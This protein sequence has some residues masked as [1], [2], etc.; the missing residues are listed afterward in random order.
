M[1]EREERVALLA[2]ASGLAGGH[3]LGAL[4]EAPDFAR[5]YA[6]TRR[7]LGREHPRLA[8]RIV[9]FDRLEQQLKGV[10]CHTAFCCLGAAPEQ[11]PDEAREVELGYVLAFARA[12]K[13]ARAERFVF[14]SCVGAQADARKT[15]LRVKQEA[16]RALEGVG[17]VSLDILQPGPLVG[18]RREI[19]SADLLA[20]GHAAF[21]SLTS[22]GERAVQRGISARTVANAM[23][24]AARSGRRG[25]YRNTYSGIGMLARSKF[26]A[27][28]ARTPVLS[29]GPRPPSG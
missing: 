14:L 20:L 10:V 26:R 7:P 28:P 9:P 13:A 19:R 12:A 16:E 27:Q 18:I 22:F 21:L 15:H 17:F 6:V 5:V 24:G 2:G 23:L 8:N 11:T 1:G 29:T 4:L 3:L 25:V